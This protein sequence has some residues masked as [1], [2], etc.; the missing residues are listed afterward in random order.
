MHLFFSIVFMDSGS[1][2]NGDDLLVLRAERDGIE[3]AERWDHR[4]GRGGCRTGPMTPCPNPSSRHSSTP[5]S[6]RFASPHTSANMRSWLP[7]AAAL[8][9][10]CPAAR[11]A[12]WPGS[13][14]RGTPRRTSY[15]S[16]S[17]RRDPPCGRTSAW[18]VLV[19]LPACCSPQAYSP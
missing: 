10:L 3:S 8:R 9:Q 15:T 1:R 18:T 7:A 2:S 13:A 11:Q 6:S 14:E 12:L 19:S 16:G 4:K 5:C 17:S